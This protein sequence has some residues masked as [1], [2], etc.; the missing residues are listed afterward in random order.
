MTLG[1]H[2]R[3]SYL[4]TLPSPH[5]STKPTKDD[6]DCTQFSVISKLK[7][8]FHM[9]ML[10]AVSVIPSKWQ[11]HQLNNITT[12][13][14]CL[15]QWNRANQMNLVQRTDY[16]F[17]SGCKIWAYHHNDGCIPVQA[18]CGFRQRREASLQP[19]RI[20]Q[21]THR[22]TTTATAWLGIAASRTISAASNTDDTWEFINRS[23]TFYFRQLR[24]I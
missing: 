1:Q 21:Q 20:H 4:T 7:K 8:W 15:R 2:M 14:N 22:T 11:Q 13:C 19:Q 6:S 9:F 17:Q 24:P 18:W 10:P 16:T 23:I 12:Q 5:G 3:L